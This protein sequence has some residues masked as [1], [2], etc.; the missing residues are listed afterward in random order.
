MFYD[1]LERLGLIHCKVCKDFAVDFD[2][3]F[4]QCAHE[5]AV[6]VALEACGS[7]DTLDPECAEGAFFVFT[8]AIS[9]LETLLPSVFGNSPNVG[10]A[11]KIASR[12]A[13]DL[14][15][16]VARSNVIY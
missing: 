16:T 7:V 4:L 2:T 10:T 14:L 5:L 13:H 12:E 1:G 9:I 3:R 6:T 8:I 11:T 15:T